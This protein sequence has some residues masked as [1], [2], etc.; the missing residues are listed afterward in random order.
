MKTSNID[1]TNLFK[2]LLPYRNNRIEH[3]EKYNKENEL[4]LKDY[5]LV[6]IDNFPG[7]INDEYKMND[8]LRLINDSA[9]MGF[10]FIINGKYT[11]NI[12]FKDYV[13][14][15]KDNDISKEFSIKNGNI[16][17]LDYSA[18]NYSF[19]S[20]KEDDIYQYKRKIFLYNRKLDTFLLKDKQIYLDGLLDEN[21]KYKG[22][23]IG[24]GIDIPVA[25]T[26]EGKV[27]TFSTDTNKNPFAVLTGTTG[28]GKTA[29][30]HTLI[31]CGALKYSP[32][33][34]QF[35][36]ADFKDKQGSADFE[37]YTYKEGVDN[38]YIPH[39]KYLSTKSSR[40]SAFDML[41]LINR[42][43]S[44]NLRQIKEAGFKDF[45]TYNSSEKVKNG[46]L[47]KIPQK[48]FIIDE[49]ATMVTG[50]GDDS[51]LGDTKKILDIIADILRRIRTSGV[52]VIFSGQNANILPQETFKFFKN[53]IVFDLAL[54]DPDAIL[55]A[56]NVSSQDV[57][58]NDSKRFYRYITNKQGFAVS[59]RLNSINCVHGIYCG[60][61]GSEDINRITNLIRKRCN[62]KYPTKQIVPGSD[63][64]EP[65]NTFLQET[66]ALK[67]NRNLIIS[68]GDDLAVENEYNMGLKQALYMGITNTTSVP[69]ALK[70]YGSK[71]NYLAVANDRKLAKINMNAIMSALYETRYDAEIKNINYIS[72]Q[73]SD[74]VNIN[75][76][77]VGDLK[78]FA[79]K[80]KFIKNRVNIIEDPNESFDKILELYKLLYDRKTAGIKKKS[81]VDKNTPYFL[82]INKLDWMF[83]EDILSE[84]NSDEEDV[85]EETT[86]SDDMV[87]MSEFASMFSD[88]GLGASDLDA[89]N[90]VS[91]TPMKQSH[92]SGDIVKALTTILNEGPNYNIFGVMSISK[93]D[94]FKNLSTDSFLNHKSLI[95]GSFEMLNTGEV[96]EFGESMNSCY[97]RSE[98]DNSVVRLYDYSNNAN[99]WWNN[100]KKV[101][102]GG[103]N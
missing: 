82:F 6:F 3:I 96:K 20:I 10:I 32:D 2:E 73:F 66:I 1:D 12:V 37:Q 67:E 78:A 88:V 44:E 81:S 16:E 91:A 43:A 85:A 57:S 59:R 39:V 42:C 63:S 99:K 102:D 60:D 90:Q 100:L 40:E 93:P 25:F 17:L 46:K 56:L 68:S 62:N 51:S 11:E 15:D 47:P 92:Q 26:E 49:Y 7:C 22:Y 8:F 79:N 103:N 97:I 58:S 29:F 9:R 35:Y 48:Y 71:P 65:A 98:T 13:G 41:D 4:S 45:A 38:M 14:N 64:L 24:E 55:E 54:T 80:Y 28:S 87:D 36:I 77:A 83:D 31:L 101:Y 19:D 61:I 69:T 33:E 89:F 94:V 84:L 70:Y 30:L 75:K 27:Y 18:D 76:L 86:T 95:L 74:D 72:V 50:G 53:Q 34:L 5:Y 21:A 52:G 23:N